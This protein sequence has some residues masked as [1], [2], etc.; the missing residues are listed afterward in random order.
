MQAL[1][2]LIDNPSEI[3]LIGTNF[4]NHGSLR[5]NVVPTDENGNYDEDDE[6]LFVEEPE[7][8]LQRHRLDF[9]IEIERAE[10]LPIN[11][12][13]DVF[14]EYQLFLD[15]TKYKTSVQEGKNRNPEINYRRQHTQEPVTQNFLNYL[16][17]ENI[18]FKLFGFPDV[19]KKPEGLKK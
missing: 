2:N 8:L 17:N 6:D 16:L 1:A 12:C 7:E 4:L 9:A 3:V 19:N 13:K 5:V 11:F 18:V 15:D 10:N 14:V